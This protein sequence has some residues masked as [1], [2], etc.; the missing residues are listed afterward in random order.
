MNK[1]IK[2]GEKTKMSI[3]K[4]GQKVPNVYKLGQK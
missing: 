4:T 3:P 2:I 1:I